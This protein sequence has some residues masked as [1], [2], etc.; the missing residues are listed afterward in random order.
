MQTFGYLD[1]LRSGV[2]SHTAL[3]CM[4]Q[5]TVDQNILKGVQTPGF[6]EQRPDLVLN[7]FA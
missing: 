1:S 6:P 7:A 5:S 3:R 4:D 2:Q